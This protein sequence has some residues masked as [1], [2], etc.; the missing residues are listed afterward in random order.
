M[1]TDKKKTLEKFIFDNEL[2]NIVK[3]IIFKLP[4]NI[5]TID[6]KNNTYMM[7]TLQCSVDDSKRKRINN[8]PRIK[9]VKKTKAILPLMINEKLRCINKNLQ[10]NEES[11]K[12]RALTL[13][14]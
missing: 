2:Y 14:K 7:N 5:Q 3:D 13:N 9:C 8:I 1:P 10:N 12:I 6:L 4:K 11:H